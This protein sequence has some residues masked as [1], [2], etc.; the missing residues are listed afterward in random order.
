[1]PFDLNLYTALLL[2]PVGL[3]ILIKAAGVLVDG[4]V[5]LA[6]KFGL[7]HMIIGLTVV[8]MGT[9]AP[10]VAASITAA[11]KGSGDMAIGN[12][13]GSNIANLALV[14]GVCA[15]IR[16]IR[17][18]LTMLRRELPVMVIVALFIWP[19]LS[20][21]Y[22]SRPESIVLLVVFAVVICASV[23]FGLKDSKAS[24]HDLSQ[25][26]EQVQ[27]SKGHAERRLYVSIAM[28]VAGLVGLTVGA[29]IAVE[30]AE[31]I[32]KMIGLSDAVI[33]ITILAVGTS[34]PEL[35]TCIV[36]AMKGHD[37][38]SIGNLVG[39]N[40][41]NTLLVVGAAGVIKPFGVTE[42]LIGIDYWIMI[43]VSAGFMLVAM[44]F[45]KISKKAGMLLLTT[46]VAYILY[47][48]I[49]NPAN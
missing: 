29:K 15:I 48:L 7:S 47:T 10:E 37:D 31:F 11:L 1:M 45:K 30:S 14:G 27:E 22:L 32:G 23:Y 2:F 38:L 5:S 12:V 41:F 4:A 46:Y 40:V 8:A 43:A 39:S 34:L 20:N 16:P 49:C 42:R 24:P 28:I 21:L 44:V 36:A 3:A 35:M 13:Y 19:V 25:I 17:I 33:G 6:E 9:S 26:K 18:R